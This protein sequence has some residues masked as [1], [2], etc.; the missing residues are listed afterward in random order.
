MTQPK[1]GLGRGLDS[2][3]PGRPA[4]GSLSAGTLPG[5]GIGAAATPGMRRGPDLLDIDLISPN[6]E[7]PRTNFEPE[8]LRELADSIREHGIIQPLIVTRDEQ[9]G[10]RLIAGERRL[11]AAR[12]AGLDTVPVVIREAADAKL[13]ELALIENIQRADLNAIEEANAYRRLIEEYHLTQEEA[14]R[15]VGK[16][17]VAV[18]N[19][20]R[21][22]NLETEIRRSLVA[23]E[24]SEGHARA[25]LGLPE[26]KERMTAWREV[27]KRRLSV[28]DTEGLVRRALAATP[29]TAQSKGA[30]TARRDAAITDIE[31][32]LRRALST[33]VSV[34]PQKKGARIT[35]DCFSAEEFDNVV[36]MLLGEDE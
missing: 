12:L 16:S 35:I 13:L 29:A 27:L 11:Q 31:S 20:L 32:R 19:A 18:A 30:V 5:D 15:R 1:R 10:Y 34:V 33:R 22:L 24:I 26:G 9:G 28:R 3:I 25:L 23:G 14:S 17:R 21:L 8:G 36:T 2:L 6:P 7:Q 4:G